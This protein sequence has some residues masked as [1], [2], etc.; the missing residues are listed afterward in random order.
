MTT[1]N[2]TACEQALTNLRADPSPG[3]VLLQTA[4]IRWLADAMAAE[5]RRETSPV[6]NEVAAEREAQRARFGDS[7]DDERDGGELARAAAC[8]ALPPI[9]RTHLLVVTLLWPFESESWKPGPRRRELIKA[10]ALLVAEIERI[11]RFAAR[12]A[13]R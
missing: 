6:I 9:E 12:P 3:N 10:A 2:L 4:S 13:P 5:A 11:D 7:H 8:Y 1:A